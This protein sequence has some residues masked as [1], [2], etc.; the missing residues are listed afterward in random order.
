MTFRSFIRPF[1]SNSIT[2]TGRFGFASTETTSTKSNV[3]LDLGRHGP[4]GSGAPVYP[5]TITITANYTP[6]GTAQNGGTFAFALGFGLASTNLDAAID[7]SGNFVVTTPSGTLLYEVQ[8][9][10]QNGGNA[11]F[12]YTTPGPAPA[13]E[14][15]TWAAGLATTLTTARSGSTASATPGFAFSYA[16]DQGG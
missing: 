16:V 3:T 8:G 14:A 11:T 15:V 9:F 2:Q 4:S 12:S 1:K 10:A 13:A 5:E 6:S 7:G